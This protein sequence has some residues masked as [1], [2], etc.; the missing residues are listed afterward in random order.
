M[1]HQPAKSITFKIAGWKAQPAAQPHTYIL[2]DTA[3]N[4]SNEVIEVD[5]NR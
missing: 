5:R 1:M 3:E 2:V 4:G